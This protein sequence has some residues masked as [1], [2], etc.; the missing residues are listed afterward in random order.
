MRLHTLLV[1]LGDHDLSGPADPEIRGLAEDSRLVK[2]GWLFACLRGQHDDGHRYARFAREAGAA[3]L[4]VEEKSAGLPGLTVIRVPD[5]RLALARASA[6]F[7]GHPS[8]SLRLYGVTGTNG[9]TTTAFMIQWIL[10]RCGR[11]AGLIGTVHNQVGPVIFPARR[12]TPGAIEF[13]ELLAA[14]V[15]AGLA[16]CAAEV[17]SHA[18]AQHRVAGARFAAAVLTNVSRDHFDYH[19]NHQNYLAA[20]SR[21]FADLPADGWAVLNLDDPSY[22]RIEEVCPGRIIT[23]GFNPAADVSGCVLAADPEGQDLRIDIRSRPVRLR[24]PLPGRGNA[25]NALAALALAEAEGIPPDEAA[26]ALAAFPGVPGR[27]ERIDCG[28]PFT[29]LIDFAHNPAALEEL[30]ETL[31]PHVPGRLIL[32]FGC[33]GGK[34]RGKRP[35]MGR[36]AAASSDFTLITC[37]NLYEEEAWPVF[38]QIREGFYAAGQKR[39]PPCRF[40]FSRREAIARAIRMARPGDAVIIAGRGHENRLILGGAAIPFDD[41]QVVREILEKQ[42][43]L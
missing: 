36:I 42:T 43:V 38:A 20:K 2:P 35:L 40:L 27:F 10:N 33:E 4:L 22:R 16:A 28:Q 12:T 39:R 15:R 32:V 24:L 25:A 1:E 11:P 31:K 13:Q 29:V 30:L 19:Q 23:Y 8:R 3:A 37:D 34:D 41:R 17:S 9:K 14:M 5:A 6:A 21:L 26:G 7:F 18:L